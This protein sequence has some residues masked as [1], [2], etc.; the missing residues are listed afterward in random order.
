MS[1]TITVHTH[2]GH[3]EVETTGEVPDGRHVISG[4]EGD[5]TRYVDVAR[6]HAEG[7]LLVNAGH[8]APKKG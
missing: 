3:V 1:Y 6:Y 4:R 8:T 2:E 7:H 5:D